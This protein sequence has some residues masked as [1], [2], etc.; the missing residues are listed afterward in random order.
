MDENTIKQYEELV[1][2]SK[3]IDAKLSL[4]SSLIMEAS[5]LCKNKHYTKICNIKKEL[6]EY[7]AEI[8]NEKCGE[9][10]Y[11]SWHDFDKE[12]AAIFDQ[13]EFVKAI[14]STGWSTSSWFC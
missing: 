8:E 5:V 4:A 7:F 14:E 12:I 13:D 3:E 2:T 6:G 10:H 1:K 11:F 9:P